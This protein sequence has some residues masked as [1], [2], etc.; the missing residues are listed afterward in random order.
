MKR[1]VLFI[2]L[3]T[4]SSKGGIQKVNENIINVLIDNF[5][6]FNVVSLYDDDLNIYNND[7]RFKSFN[8]NK[9][10]FIFYFLKQKMDYDFILLDHYNLLVLSLYFK[11]L[12]NKIKIYLYA[13]GIEMWDKKSLFSKFKLLFVTKIISVSDYTKNRIQN[14][15]L[16]P[17]NKIIVINNSLPKSII[18]PVSNLDSCINK[19]N[20]PLRLLTVSRFS[21]NDRFKGYM[22]VLNS[23][24]NYNEINF[25]YTM[26]GNFEINE[27]SLIREK[28]DMYKLNNKVELFTNP[29]NLILEQL[30]KNSD[31]FIMP[32]IKEGFGIVF[33][34]AGYYGLSII[35]SNLDGSKEAV[36]DVNHSCLISSINTFEIRQSIKRL[37]NLKIDKF[38]VSTIYF[39][40]YNFVNYSNKIMEL[41]IND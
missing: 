40:R 7:S 33:I 9:I 11:F 3:K 1:K 2:Y 18:N 38:Q 27:L 4:F 34:E 26:A 23:L 17:D 32:S 37:Y 39:N 28:I 20:I 25:I 19:K 6:D 10:K 14:N 31:I 8:G 5:N 13:H 21:I 30:Y 16:I 29:D 15:L 12:N 24:H 36:A 41:F 35:A 22:E